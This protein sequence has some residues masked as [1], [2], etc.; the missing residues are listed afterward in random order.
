MKLVQWYRQNLSNSLQIKSDHGSWVSKL[1]LLEGFLHKKSPKSVIGQHIWQRRYFVFTATY[2]M[3]FKKQSDIAK[4]LYLG[5]I[6]IKEIESVKIINTRHT[7]RFRFNIYLF[8]ELT[9]RI[10]ELYHDN[11][12]LGNEWVAFINKYMEFLNI[13]TTKNLDQNIH[14]YNHQNILDT[15]GKKFWKRKIYQEIQMKKVVHGE[16]INTVSLDACSSPVANDIR[17][18]ETLTTDIFL[19]FTET[20]LSNLLTTIDDSLIFKQFNLEPKERMKLLKKMK[21]KVISTGTKVWSKGKHCDSF[22]LR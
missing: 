11:N 6:P 19:I 12:V 22:F 7:S 16:K 18:Q 10:F 13:D 17:F 14:H 2:L 21:R 1:S 4:Y 20:S 15:Q 3:Y 8:G 5:I 9:D